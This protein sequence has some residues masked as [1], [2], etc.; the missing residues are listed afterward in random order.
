VI[1]L[2][3]IGE[4]KQGFINDPYDPN[5]LVQ[6]GFPSYCPEAF[7]SPNGSLTSAP[8]WPETDYFTPPFGPSQY[9]AKWNFFDPS[10]NANGNNPPVN[11]NST[12]R[13][14]DAQQSPTNQF[15]LDAIA[16]QGAIILPYSYTSAYL[17]GPHEFVF[18]AYT[19]C[20]STPGQGGFGCN[21]LNIPNGGDKDYTLDQDVQTLD[22]EIRSINAVWPKTEIVL[23]G[24][25]QGGL[26]AWMWWHAHPG[27]D[28]VTHAFSLDSPI[29]GVVAQFSPQ[30]G[31]VV[32]FDSPLPPGYP[33]FSPR[34]A[35]DKGYLKQDAS[36]FD[37]FGVSD[38]FRFVGTW[39]DSP[40]VKLCLGLLTQFGCVGR[41]LG[42]VYSYGGPNGPYSDETLQHELLVSGASCNN[43]GTTTA[44]PSPPDHVSGCS[45]S[46]SSLDWIKEDSHFIVKFCPN[47]V[48]YFN[49]TLRLRY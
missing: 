19:R 23:I 26:I 11:S 17:T 30:P 2:D 44:C 36:Y 9:F 10:D 34:V 14:L 48:S 24:H 33:K 49:S 20:N 27:A 1:L 7:I 16:A 29:N 38:P 35:H 3:G 12:P 21:D 37:P 28:Y 41:D 47:V 6:D 4:S 45:I 40:A 42:T 46:D 32:E 13:T 15:M 8:S 43:Q 18:T 25:S 5:D 39:G 31:L 22:G